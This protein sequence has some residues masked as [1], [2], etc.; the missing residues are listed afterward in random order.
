M[1]KPEEATVST[2]GGSGETIKL[3]FADINPYEGDDKE[4]DR[5]DFTIEYP[6][7]ITIEDEKGNV[8]LKEKSQ[9]TLRAKD[10]NK[11]FY[12]KE[13]STGLEYVAYTRWCSLLAIVM[14]KKQKVGE[15]PKEINL[16]D[17]VGFEFDAQI[18][19]IEGRDPFIDW[20]GTFMVNGVPTPSVD[21]LRKKTSSSFDA[22]PVESEKKAEPKTD[23]KKG[24]W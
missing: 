24:A 3:K 4:E 17:L 9:S 18:I 15:L 21:E 19:K 13:G 6:Y 8:I 7:Q 16:N 2:I 11:K 12:I 1:L 22:E 10:W 5:G 23:S 20:V 14:I